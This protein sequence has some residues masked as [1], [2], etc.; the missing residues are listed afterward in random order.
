[1]FKSKFLFQ[2]SFGSCW[3][4]FTPQKLKVRA[5]KS[6]TSIWRSPQI[7]FKLCYRFIWFEAIFMFGPVNP[8]D[9]VSCF[10][11]NLHFNHLNR[12]FIALVC[13]WNTLRGRNCSD[14]RYK[15]LKVTL[16]FQHSN[17]CFLTCYLGL[18]SSL[19]QA[20]K[21]CQYWSS[22]CAS[23]QPILRANGEVGDV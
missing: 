13:L 14:S 1:M 4:T 19:H 5:S 12:S 15:A 16:V 23:N 9:L 18:F 10:Q 22:H 3:V 2:I 20:R 8:Q 21:I 11:F 6:C 7:Y 17:R